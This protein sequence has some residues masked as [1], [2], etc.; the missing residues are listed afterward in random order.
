MIIITGYF[1]IQIP[2]AALVKGVVGFV[3]SLDS[4]EDL[5]SIGQQIFGYV[6]LLITNEA[7]FVHSKHTDTFMLIVCIHHFP[8]KTFTGTLDLTNQKA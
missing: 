4:V 3:R 6:N 7:I 1:C 2:R 8:K 5:Q